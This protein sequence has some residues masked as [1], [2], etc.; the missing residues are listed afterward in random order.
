MVSKEET[1]EMLD[2]AYKFEDV[3][4]IRIKNIMLVDLL[5]SAISAEKR[6]EGRKYLEELYAGSVKHAE[7]LGNWRLKILRDGINDY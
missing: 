3:I 1:L 7:M 6:R 4:M 5:W 2:K